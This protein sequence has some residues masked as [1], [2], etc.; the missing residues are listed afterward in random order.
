[1]NEGHSLFGFNVN[2][3]CYCGK[4]IKLK[5]DESESIKDTKCKHC[6]YNH[7]DFAYVLRKNIENF[8]KSFIDN[9]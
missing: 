6:G 9:S 4:K 2:I 7:M 1:M 5:Y 3:T 8:A